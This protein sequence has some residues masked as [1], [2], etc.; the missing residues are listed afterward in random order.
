VRAFLNS[1]RHRGSRIADGGGVAARV[2]KCP[3]HAW[4]YD[5]DGR[6]LGQP[7]AQDAFAE[8]PRHEL[9]LV[10]LPVAE[11]GGLI[12]LIPDA[13]APTFD[14]VE[15]LAGLSPELDSHRFS[16]FRLF[17]EQHHTVQCNWK[18][19]YETFLEA[20]HVFALHRETLSRQIMSTPMLADFHGRHGR[21]VL[22]GRDTMKALD[23]LDESEWSLRD[24][25]AN[26]VYWLFPNAILSLPM[27]GHA[28]LWLSYPDP[29]DPGI[30]RVHLKFYVHGDEGS[31]S[32]DPFWKRMLDYTSTI[33]LSEDFEQ[34]A[35]IYRG[36]ASGSHPGLVF[37]RNEPAL[38]HYHRELDAALVELPGSTQAGRREQK[39]T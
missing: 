21:G 31:D 11:S 18:Q 20:Y 26:L 4:C 34:Q 15:H 32:R 14:G 38:I 27:T 7:T 17:A 12:I 25:S 24:V 6:L 3:Y 35:Q 33:V 10:D 37:G 29:F 8:L 39:I 16:D 28:E 2:F 5:I 19:P 13:S 9:G 1:C 23:N 36:L 22:T 30:T